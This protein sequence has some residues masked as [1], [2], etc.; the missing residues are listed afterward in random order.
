M[1]EDGDLESAAGKYL[2]I[3]NLNVKKIDHLTNSINKIIYSYKI[4]KR[5]FK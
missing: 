3:Q 5:E 2:P 1:D 4:K